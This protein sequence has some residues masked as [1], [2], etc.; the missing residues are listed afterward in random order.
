MLNHVLSW[1]A[2]WLMTLLVEAS[3]KQKKGINQTSVS[4]GPR[5]WGHLLWVGLLQV[6]GMSYYFWFVKNIAHVSQDEGRV[7]GKPVTV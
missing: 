2:K 5:C 3:T 4:G 1:I 7:T 6:P